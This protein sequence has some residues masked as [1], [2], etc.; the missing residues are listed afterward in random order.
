[1]TRFDTGF[2]RAA[3]GE[4]ASGP[5]P[6]Y[7]AISTDTRTL[8]PG[9]LFVAL[10]GERFDGHDHLAAARA[11]G[12]AGAVVR[13]GTAPIPGLV[14]HPVADTLRAYGR[15]ARAHRDRLPGPVVAVAGSNGK[16]STRAMVA[17]VLATGHRTHATRGN[18]NNLVGVPLTILEAPEGTGALVVEAGASE[19]GEVARLREIIG[20]DVGV[21]TNVGE[22]H[23][24]GFGSLAGVLE[25]ELALADGV[26]LVVVGTDPPALAEGAR[27]RAGRTVTA[28]LADADVVPSVVGLDGTGRAAVEVDGVRF[29]LPLPGRHLAANAMLAWAL[30]R[31]WG[32]DRA[33]A[34]S[35]LERLEV[36]GGR[37]EVVEAAGLLILNDSYNANPASFRAA[38]A[39]AQAMRGRRR[40]VFLAGTMRE[41]GASAPAL[42]AG[43]ARELVALEPDLLGAVGDFVPALA[44]HAGHLGDRL[45]T[46]PDP[47]ALGAL[48]APRLRP[49]DLV[50]LKASRGVALERILPLLTGQPTSSSH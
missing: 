25:E 35:A 5:S 4:P 37:S 40:L 15:L 11:A 39:T 21:I 47:E 49:G 12:A 34:A 6:G 26:P 8:L 45:L 36:P 38:I 44:P 14:L 23:L 48:V 43:I 20:P 7:T 33:A 9:A 32:L 18:L 29:R 3:L 13:A 46:A 50:V 24:E 16:T 17:A 22:E 2:V 10:R 30:V 28:G 42:H 19:P 31:E 41:M 27:R 1:M